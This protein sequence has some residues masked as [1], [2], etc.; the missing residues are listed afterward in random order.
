LAIVAYRQPVTKP[1]ID[2]IRGVDCS[3]TLRLLLDRGLTRIVG[4]KEEPGLPLLYGTTKEFLSFFNLANLAQLPTLREYHELTEDSQEELEAFD[5]EMG[6]TDLREAAQRLSSEQ[7][8]AVQDL[9]DAMNRLKNT[10]KNARS[11]LEEQGVVL[12]ESDSEA[13]AGTGAQGEPMSSEAP[14]T[15]ETPPESSAS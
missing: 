14:S 6:V 5:T 9:E 11:A 2:H 4:K 10:E 13:T 1:E 7:E 15:P 3:A 8:P 12:Q